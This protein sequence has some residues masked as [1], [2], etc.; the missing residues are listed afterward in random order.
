[1]KIPSIYSAVILLWFSFRSFGIIFY[2][3]GDASHNTTAPGIIDGADASI[4]WDLQGNFAGCLGTPIAPNYFITARHIGGSIG[5]TI[6]FS[7]GLNAGLYTTVA[8]YDSPISDLRIWEISGTF[9]EFAELYT[10]SDEAGKNLVVFGRGTQRGAEYHGPLG[11]SDI[12]G[13]QWGAADGVKRWGE[14]NVAGFTTSGSLLVATFSSTGGTEEEATLSVG[15]S[16][17]A[18]FI[19][20]GG[21]W[22]LAGIN[23]AVSGAYYSNTGESGSGVRAAIYDQSSLY[24]SAN[25]VTFFG[26]LAGPG[27]F[28]SSRISFETAWIDSIIPEPSTTTMLLGALMILWIFGRKLL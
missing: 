13:W 1:M 25:N 15:D 14:N 8:F 6:S 2:S 28:Y 26:P 12:R 19:Q 18:V 4:A 10:N 16:G 17:G 21:T 11:D 7:D 20:D 3:N 24:N 22:K 23:Y 27:L 9:N 5:Q